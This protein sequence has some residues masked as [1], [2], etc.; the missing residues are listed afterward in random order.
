MTGRAKLKTSY[1]KTV[2][3]GEDKTVWHRQHEATGEFLLNRDFSLGYDSFPECIGRYVQGLVRRF[4]YPISLLYEPMS[5]P[6]SFATLTWITEPHKKETLVKNSLA[7]GHSRAAQSKESE[8][9][10]D[11]LTT[12]VILLA[13]IMGIMALLVVFDSGIITRMIGG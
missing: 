9:R 1:L 11:R 12:A 5:R 2:C 3:I 8:A 7:D 6:F 10:V 4:R 13:A